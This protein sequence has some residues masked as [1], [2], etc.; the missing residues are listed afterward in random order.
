ML[1]IVETWWIAVK[2]LLAIVSCNGH[3]SRRRAIHDHL[4]RTPLLVLSRALCRR[5]D[6]VTE[7]W[8]QSNDL[9]SRCRI[10]EFVRGFADYIG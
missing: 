6:I 9:V 5:H 4:D 10:R 7:R 2:K 1:T 8:R 3:D